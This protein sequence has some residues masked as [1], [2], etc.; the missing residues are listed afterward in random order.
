MPKDLTPDELTLEKAKKL[1]EA[2][3]AAPKRKF[4]KKK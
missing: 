3:K 4:R 1:I 2:K